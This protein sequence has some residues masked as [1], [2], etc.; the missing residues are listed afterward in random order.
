VL[1]AGGYNGGALSAAELYSPV[2]GTWTNTG[3]MITARYGHTATLL[4][5]GNVLVAGGEGVSYLDN[6]ELYISASGRWTNTASMATARQYHTATLLTNGMVLV[7]GG[8]NGSELTS[9]AL[10]NPTSG[11][12]T[13]SGLLNTARQYHTATLL[14]NGKVLVAGGLGSGGVFLSSAELYDPVL[15][16]WTPTASLTT[17]RAYHSATL[18]P[19]GKVLVAGGDNSGPLIFAELYDPELGTWTATGSLNHSRY[20][21]T[22]ALLA[23]GKVLALGG[24]GSGGAVLSSAEL[25]NVG[26]GF[27]A[28]WQ[29]QIASATSPLGLG[30]S[31]VIT[32]SQFRGISEASGS[33]GSQDSPADY[34]VVQLLRLGN[35]QT[36][37][38]LPTSWSSNSYVSAAVGGLP[39]GY[40]LVTVFVNGIPSTSSILDIT[41][42]VLP[43]LPFQITSIVRT[44]ANDLLIT[45]NTIGTT[46]YVQ[47][48]AGVGPSGSYS[49]FGFIDVTNLVITTAT[50]N[51][52]DVGA[53]TNM[54]SRYYRIWSP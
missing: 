17:G 6:A 32:G 38:L 7:A 40:A 2:S 24:I 16:T 8:Y 19:N 43:G 53:L 35:E 34:P 29:P 36:A 23:N 47:I 14:P 41:P 18:L 1:A 3:L 15:G 31:L 5:N 52:L 50:T 39:P 45:R 26:L 20:Y 51:F 28:S 25:Y 48:N 27:N 42:S 13:N 37:F 11:T 46:N 22:A 30:S 9:T 49:G 33:N 54:P 44:N 12:W 10:Y 4:T 21:L